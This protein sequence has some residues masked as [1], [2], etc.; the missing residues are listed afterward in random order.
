MSAMKN[1]EFEHLSGFLDGAEIG[2]GWLR[3]VSRLANVS[4]VAMRP[5]AHPH[6]ELIFCLKGEFTYSIENIGERTLGAGSGMLIPPGTVHSLLNDIDTPGE[7]VGLHLLARTHRKPDFAIFSPSDYLALKSR[8]L[9][10]G[11]EPFRLGKG[12]AEHVR[13]LSDLV[14]TERNLVLGHQAYVRILACSI[15]YDVAE[16]STAPI[17]PLRPELIESAADYFRRHLSEN[18]DISDVVR[19]VGYG[20]A[21]F[22]ALFR[23][24]FHLPPIQYLNRL[25]I[26]VACTLLKT[27]DLSVRDIA[28]R[29]GIKDAS[30]FS[31]LFRRH[32]TVSPIVW[33][34]RQ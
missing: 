18:I 29:V 20:R 5:H 8:I 12:L 7:R 13:K 24:R 14:G 30:Y 17:E 19:Y 22:F 31:T 3:G 11:V 32:T 33:R 15:L 27:T 9:S 34:Q 23:E 2:L 1:A 21:R 26:D 16:A 4:A 28:A 10:R 25:R 6:A